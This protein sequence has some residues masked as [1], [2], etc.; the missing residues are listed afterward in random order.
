MMELEAGA[1]ALRPFLAGRRALLLGRRVVS[2]FG[3]SELEPLDWKV[4]DCGRGAG[5][6]RASS[7]T[8]Q[9]AFLPHPSGRNRWYNEQRNTDAARE[10]LRRLLS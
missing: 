5:W 2:A 4:I 8:A 10:F 7:P 3:L 6:N 9:V 1:G